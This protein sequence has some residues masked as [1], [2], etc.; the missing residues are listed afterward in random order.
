MEQDFEQQLK[1]KNFFS[2]VSVKEI[3]TNNIRTEFI[4]MDNGTDR[5]TIKM[6]TFDDVDMSSQVWDNLF[7]YLE[8]DDE[9]DVTTFID[10]LEDIG[11][12]IVEEY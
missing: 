11:I 7:T 12:E 8:F 10:L 2:L 9:G 4:T 6:I 5:P 1:D 3:Y